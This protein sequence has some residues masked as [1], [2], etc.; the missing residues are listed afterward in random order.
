MKIKGYIINHY[1]ANT[2]YPE[3]PYYSQ[4]LLRVTSE[5]RF[6]DMVLKFNL[7]NNT[8]I[9]ANTRVFFEAPSDSSQI[10]DLTEQNIIN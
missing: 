10:V 8:Q 1:P 9:P 7:P 2:H 4:G 3:T 5:G 6:K